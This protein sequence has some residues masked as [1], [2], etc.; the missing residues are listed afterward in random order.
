MG[1]GLEGIRPWAVGWAWLKVSRRGGLCWELP[2]PA[3]LWGGE[4]GVEPFPGAGADCGR[5]NGWAI[6][7]RGGT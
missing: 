1:W 4:W 5:V 7:W 6:G 2:A 3:W